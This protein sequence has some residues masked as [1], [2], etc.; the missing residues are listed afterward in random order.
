MQTKQIL[1]ASLALIIIAASGTAIAGPE[2]TK[3]RDKNLLQG[4]DVTTTPAEPTQ[5]KDKMNTMESTQD[6]RADHP[7]VFREYMLAYRQINNAQSPSANLNLT[8]AQQDQIKKIMKDQREAMT[9]FQEE[10]R[11]SMREMRQAQRDSSDRQQKNPIQNR[12]T[13]DSTDKKQRQQNTDRPD[14]RPQRDRAAQSREKF[15][16]FMDNAPPNKDA[17]FKLMQVLT[18]DQQSI[19]KAHIHKNRTQRAQRGQPGQ[20][21]DQARPNR[22]ERDSET[23]TNR[24]RTQ[25]RQL[26]SDK[27]NN[28]G[29]KGP[30]R[31]KRSKSDKPTPEDD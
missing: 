22:T 12:Q 8:T 11:D 14:Q 21:P 26:D 25:R 23:R 31:T 6:K 20:R 19:L 15:R 18:P 17:L 10:N 3:E 7:M 2:K 30:Q 16:A 4:P 24:Q 9:A 1:N 5:H 27:V 29:E 13:T 28:T